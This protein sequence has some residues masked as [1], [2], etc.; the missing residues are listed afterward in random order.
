MVDVSTELRI[1][2]YC[3]ICNASGSS[4]RGH[5]ASVVVEALAEPACDMQAMLYHA[6]GM[7]RRL[8]C[9]IHSAALTHLKDYQSLRLLTPV[10]TDEVQV[11]CICCWLRFTVQDLLH[12]P[13]AE[14]QRCSAWKQFMLHSFLLSHQ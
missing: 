7:H 6:M 4:P 9:C 12:S 2:S 8:V 10:V 13:L 5:S 1:T 11:H 3:A 14:E